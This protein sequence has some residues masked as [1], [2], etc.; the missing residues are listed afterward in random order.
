MSSAGRNDGTREQHRPSTEYSVAMQ[1]IFCFSR[2]APDP[3]RT[4]RLEPAV[5]RLAVDDDHVASALATLAQPAPKLSVNY[6]R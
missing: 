2:R 6:A 4:E 5:A 3:R 1:A